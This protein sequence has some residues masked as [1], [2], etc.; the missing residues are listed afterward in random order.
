M[1]YYSPHI[2]TL[3]NGFKYKEPTGQ[4]H[5][6]KKNEMIDFSVIIDFENQ[7]FHSIHR[8]HLGSLAFGSLIVA[9][10][11]LIRV[12]LEY[13]DHKLKGSDNPVAKFFMK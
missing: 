1:I 8:Y 11:Q 5:F 12:F 13:I 2:R 9:I 10:I 6:V 4:I 7:F 3:R